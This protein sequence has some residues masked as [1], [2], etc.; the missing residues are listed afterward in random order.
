MEGLAEKIKSGLASGK[1]RE[2]IYRDL[3]VSGAK[4]EELNLAFEAATRVSGEDSSKKV[5]KI[6]VTIGAVLVGLGVFSFIA[7]NWQK[8]GR[9]EKIAIITVSVVFAYSA[10]W[11]LREKGKFRRSGKAMILL[12]AILYGAGI[13]LIGQIFNIRSNWPDAFLLWGIGIVVMGFAAD[14]FSLF[15]LSIP[16]WALGIFSHPFGMFRAIPDYDPF[17]FTST[18][19]IFCSFAV[20][21]YSAF[22]VRRTAPDDV[23]DIF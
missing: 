2:D 9:A 13:F 15:Y 12:G 16:V 3:L 20:N 23:K 10:G 21:L 22:L 11:W 7:S 14:S 19:L 18:F 17:L 5:I 6:L 8:I 1:T 4:V